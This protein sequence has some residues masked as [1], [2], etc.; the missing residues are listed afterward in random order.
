MMQCQE[1][2]Q[3]LVR[4][5]VNDR[6]IPLHGCTVDRLGRCKLDNFIEGLSFVRSGGN[7]AACFVE[8]VCF[9]L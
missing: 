4:V 6:V 2:N 1:E 3:P 9:H 5:L 7:W 8:I